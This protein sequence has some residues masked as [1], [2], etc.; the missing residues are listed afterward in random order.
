[1]AD[2]LIDT[3]ER[4]WIILAQFFLGDLHDVFEMLHSIALLIRQTLGVSLICV[5]DFDCGSV[6]NLVEHDHVGQAFWG[7][8]NCVGLGVVD[9]QVIVGQRCNKLDLC[10]KL[11][12]KQFFSKLFV[13]RGLCFCAQVL[14]NTL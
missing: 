3:L 2:K 13:D 8:T 4:F 14:E 12:C 5:Q 9:S 10:T 1:M 7:D 11:H 6:Y